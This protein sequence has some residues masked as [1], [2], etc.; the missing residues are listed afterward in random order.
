MS[1]KIGRPHLPRYGG[2]CTI[3]YYK[4]LATIRKSGLYDL[5]RM[6]L[7]NPLL[8]KLHS[9]NWQ[10]HHV[11]FIITN[12]HSPHYLGIVYSVHPLLLLCCMALSCFSRHTNQKSPIIICGH[13]T[14]K[15]TIFWLTTKIVCVLIANFQNPN[16]HLHRECVL[17]FTATNTRTPTSL[18][19]LHGLA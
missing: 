2:T 9:L 19:L 5:T 8:T 3:M 10:H 12:F 11:C 1:E 7:V 14:K 6:D 15:W 18:T 4:I 17:S 13:K 16:M